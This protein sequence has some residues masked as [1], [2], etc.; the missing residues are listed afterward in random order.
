MQI[1]AQIRPTSDRSILR[2]TA[3][4]FALATFLSTTPQRSHS[5][6]FEELLSG[7]QAPLTIQ[8]QD[9]D[10]SWRL[11]SI[12]G[13]FE[14]G[15]LL[16]T[17][18][19]FFGGQNRNRSAYYTRGETVTI[20]SETYVIAYR[21]PPSGTP[22][23]FANMLGNIFGMAGC[24][25]SATPN[26]LA[27]STSL[28]LSLLN[29]RTIGSVNDIRPFNLQQTLAD[30]KKMVEEMQAACQQA[31]V[32]QV[33]ARVS[34][35]LSTLAF[36]LQGYANEHNGVLPNLD[37]PAA[38]REALESFVGD[39]SAFVH[40]MTSEP[41]QPNPSLSGKTLADIANPSATIAFYEA[42]PDADGT[43]NV[44]Y[45]DG[46]VDRIAATDWASVQQSLGLP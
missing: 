10:D 34:S 13:Q 43:R 18:N 35:S 25:E 8:L 39:P 26:P 41:Y 2:R 12:S 17:Y 32:E 1:P 45:L 19:S 7:S 42:T 30:S 27:P 24:D 20:G 40:P 16:Q 23:N 15:D 33:N 36:A 29:L 5:A 37:S 46:A 14:M 3:L 9:M 21:L 44:S 31:Q 28:T 11:I 4:I 22:L 6:E 38:A